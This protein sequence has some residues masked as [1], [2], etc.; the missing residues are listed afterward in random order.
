[1]QPIAAPSV[2]GYFA[3]GSALIIYGSWLATTWGGAKSPES[4]FPFILLFG[5]AGQF[6]AALWSYRARNAVGA[7]LHGSWAAFWLG[8][9][10]MYLME[11]T[12][13]IAVPLPGARFEALG[14][15]WM[16]MAVVTWST[17]FAALSRSPGG[18]LAQATL[19]TGASIAAASM[20]TGSSG[21]IDVAGW[22]FVAAAG[23]GF[24]V[25][26]ALMLDNVYGIVVLPL[27]HW[28]RRGNVPGREPAEPVEYEHGDPGVKVGQ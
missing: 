10:V 28:R 18:F 27:L 9:G 2:L 25:G 23:L 5:G 14:Q 11:T 6:G 15:W 20:M 7:A 16:Y 24:Y 4:F 21:W 1:L 8:I 3:L 17:A 26:A 12:K 22:L 13:T 19:A